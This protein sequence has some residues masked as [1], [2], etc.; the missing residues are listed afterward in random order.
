MNANLFDIAERGY[1]AACEM[2]HQRDLAAEEAFNEAAEAIE[3]ELA[4]NHAVVL[5]IISDVIFETDWADAVA[6]LYVAGRPDHAGRVLTDRIANH[7]KA[8]AIREQA[9]RDAK[10]AEDAVAE[11]WLERGL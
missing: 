1:E 4:T 6:T 8:R 3:N 11:R 9:A 5:D 2:H 10:A 7:I